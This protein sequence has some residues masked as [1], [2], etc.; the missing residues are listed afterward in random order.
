[1]SNEQLFYLLNRAFND[2]MYRID[3]TKFP[4]NFPGEPAY[5]EFFK[6][7]NIKRIPMFDQLFQMVQKPHTKYIL[8]FKGLWTLWYMTHQRNT[9]LKE[10]YETHI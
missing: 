6:K 2:D 9:L 8:N 5:S 10:N 3:N 1:M 7:T 4:L